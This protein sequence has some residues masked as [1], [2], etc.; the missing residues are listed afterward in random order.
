[1][2]FSPTLIY[3]AFL[4]VE[5]LASSGTV[6]LL[7]Q[8]SSCHVTVQRAIQATHICSYKRGGEELNERGKVEDVLRG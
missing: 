6:T 3:D 4:L 2:F 1:M 5:Q 7:T 8:T